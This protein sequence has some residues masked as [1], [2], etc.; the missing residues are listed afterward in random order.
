MVVMLMSASEPSAPKVFSELDVLIKQEFL[1]F[2]F[3][4]LVDMRPIFVN[5]F[6]AML[7]YTAISRYY[8]RNERVGFSD[9]GVQPSF[10]CG[11]TATRIAGLTKIPRET[12][13]R[14]LLQLEC[15][16]YLERGPRD[17]WL[18][19][20]RDGQPVIRTEYAPEWRREL[21]RIK[22][23]VKTLKDHV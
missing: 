17:E 2:F 19:S 5:D 4:E 9:G 14:K 13:R 15:R 6:D 8:L 10:D 18:V 20:R 1:E 3:G 11:L 16:G 21:E 23:F 12:V 22:R 7:I